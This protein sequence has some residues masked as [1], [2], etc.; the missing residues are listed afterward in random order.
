MPRPIPRWDISRILVQYLVRR[1]LEKRPATLKQI[2]NRLGVAVDYFLA[3]LDAEKIQY[4]RITA[5]VGWEREDK[6]VITG[7]PEKLV[8][9]QHLPK[10][11]ILEAGKEILAMPFE[12]KPEKIKLKDLRKQEKERIN[13]EKIRFFLGE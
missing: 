12:I 6:L 5:G 2:S 9:Q 7:I 10:E 3:L 11:K 1:Q 13:Q 4:T 8:L